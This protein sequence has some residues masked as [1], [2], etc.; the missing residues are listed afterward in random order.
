M[1]GLIE[2]I[3]V[4]ALPILFAITLHEAAHG[5]VAWK[6]GD[7][8]AK[9]MGR[10]SFNPMVHID[11]FGTIIMPLLLLYFT[12]FVFGYAK[13]VPVNTRNL[14]NPRR[15]SVLVALAGPA[16][17]VL[18]IIFAVMLSYTVSFL[19]A[20]LE[21]WFAKNLIYVMIFNMFLAVF[22]MIPLPPLDGG[23]VAVGILPYRFARPLAL[24]EPY[25]ML[26][27]IGIIFIIPA[28]G[29]QLGM[30]LY[31]LSYIM[32]PALEFIFNLISDLPLAKYLSS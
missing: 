21:E 22:N 5:W 25:G 2:N 17:N 8:T 15:D 12:G 4:M 11:P 30:D 7:N 9:T 16:A 27:L 20:I 10:V 23:R 3:T 26:I 29:R 19:P 6:L 31:I 24:L 32:S 13:P 28:L 18:L 14:G 1:G